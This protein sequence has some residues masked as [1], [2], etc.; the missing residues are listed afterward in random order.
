M[1]SSITKDDKKFNDLIVKQHR[2][3]E[4]FF[5]KKT[6]GVIDEDDAK[7]EDLTLLQEISEKEPKHDLIEEKYEEKILIEQVIKMLDGKSEK[8]RQSPFER[9][10][11][12]SFYNEE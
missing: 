2:N 12:D 1:E 4:G 5:V 8:N 10:F 9:V 6:S 11:E 7:M 3:A